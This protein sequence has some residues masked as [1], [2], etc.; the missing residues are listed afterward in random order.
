M[1]KRYYFSRKGKLKGERGG[2]TYGFPGAKERVGDDLSARRWDQESD[3]LVLGSLL[4]KETLIDI[5]KHLVESEFTESLQT[6]SDQRGEPALNKTNK[7][8]C[9]C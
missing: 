6:V 9:F 1:V 3:G 4:A 2:A 8:A 7:T 5:F